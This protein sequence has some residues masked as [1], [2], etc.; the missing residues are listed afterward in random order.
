MSKLSETIE[1]YWFITN[2]CLTINY[3][4]QK[5]KIIKLKN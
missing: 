1:K 5:N 3:F 2:I 4:F